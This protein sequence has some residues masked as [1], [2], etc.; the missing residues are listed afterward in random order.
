MLDMKILY[1]ICLLLLLSACRHDNNQI[2][3]KFKAY[4]HN[5]ILSPG[6]PGTW[7]EL[8]LWTPQIVLYDDVFYLFYL[9]GNVSGRMAIGIATSNDGFHFTKFSGNPV[10][11]PDDKG[12]DSFTVGPG[13]VLKS[14]STWLMYYNAQDL[15]TFAPGH[16]AGRATAA[17]MT[18]PWI[19]SETPVI[20]S[21]GTGEWDAGFIIPSTVLKLENGSYMMFYSGGEDLA[22]WDDFYTGMATS[23]DGINW[24][25]YND[26]NT[27]QHP[28]AESDPVLMTGRN[29]EWDGAFIWMAN[30]TKFPGGFRMYYSATDVN[31]RKE[32]KAIGYATSKDG[33]HWEKY[34]GN[35]VYQSKQDPFAKSHGII[36]YMEN[37]S[38]LDLDTLCLLYYECGPFQIETSYICI[39]VG[40]Y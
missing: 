15:A 19:K 6:E 17:S 12:F 38:I 3:L 32:L 40:R 35:P 1:L 21:G 31:I 29:G 8:F 18:G 23:S 2:P 16:C 5:P 39:A 9:G 4:E 20:S 34:P 33:I 7:D 14:D 22:L 28:Y 13:I 36:G 26:P 37:P 25:K 24:K 11:S 27:T 10:L 30:V